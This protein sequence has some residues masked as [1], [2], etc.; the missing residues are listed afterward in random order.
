MTSQ[1]PEHTLSKFLTETK[2]AY[3]EAVKSGK[4]HEWTVV[5]GNEAGGKHRGPFILRAVDVPT[6][7]TDPQISTR[8]RARL[9]T[10]GT[11]TT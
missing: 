11:L 9:R 5:M 7:N 1:T 2:T 6:T 10:R 8:S 4:G 3:L